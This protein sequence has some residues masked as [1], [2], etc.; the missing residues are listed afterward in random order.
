MAKFQHAL[1]S[2]SFFPQSKHAQRARLDMHLKPIP[3]LATYTILMVVRQCS[4]FL[5]TAEDKIF[6]VHTHY[7]MTHRLA[8][9]FKMSQMLQHSSIFNIVNLYNDTHIVACPP[10]LFS[11]TQSFSSSLSAG[12]CKDGMDI[13]TLL[14]HFSSRSHQLVVPADGLDATRYE[15]AKEAHTA[16][17][18]ANGSSHKNHSCGKC[19]SIRHCQQ[20][21]EYSVIRAV[22]TD[23]LTIGRYRCSASRAQLEYLAMDAGDPPPNGPCLNSLDNV[24]SRFCRKHFQLLQ[25]QCEAQPCTRPV[26]L[27]QKTCDLESHIRAETAELQDY[28][29]IQHA[30]EADRYDEKGRD[31]GVSSKES[32]PK[33]SR[34]RTHNDQLIVGACGV[35]LARQTM[36]RAESPS[37]V[38]VCPNSYSLNSA[39]SLFTFFFGSA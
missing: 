17:V 31:G 23:G 3:Y 30:N 4:T 35:V 33:L 11:P 8:H 19:T 5:L 21:D 1:H 13:H 24:R 7:F 15:E 26:M 27:G 36:F 29:D 39:V 22:V 6:H 20:P 18:R 37:A 12:V 38:K 25:K 16:Y 32:R 14:Y 2:T 9:H 34:E 28:E 10:P